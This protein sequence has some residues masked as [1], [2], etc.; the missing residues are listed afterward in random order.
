MGPRLPP[1]TP[2]PSAET[3][4]DGEGV[5]EGAGTLELP[6]A[7]A[8]AAEAEIPRVPSGYEQCMAADLRAFELGV[9]AMYSRRAANRAEE[10]ASVAGQIAA[11][12]T[13]Q[14]A[15]AIRR[16]ADAVRAAEAAHRRAA[17]ARREAD[18]LLEADETVRSLRRRHS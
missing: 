2:P 15:E 12:A 7:P 16:A 8:P 13:A 10:E 4:R 6:P 9:Q 14:H 11:E 18:R 17:D 1:P 5:E 3:R